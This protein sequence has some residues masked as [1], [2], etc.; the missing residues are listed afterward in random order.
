M[1]VEAAVDSNND[2]PNAGLSAATF[3]SLRADEEPTS[4]GLHPKDALASALPTDHVTHGS[5]RDTATQ[6]IS[7]S[8]DPSV[9]MLWALPWGRVCLVAPEVAR[10]LSVVKKGVVGES[11]ISNGQLLGQLD[12]T[13]KQ[14]LYA[15]RSREALAAGP[16]PADA[17]D[18]LSW[19]FSPVEGSLVGGIPPPVVSPPETCAFFPTTLSDLYQL[20]ETKNGPMHFIHADMGATLL[21]VAPKGFENRDLPADFVLVRMSRNSLPLKNESDGSALSMDE[22][23]ALGRAQLHRAFELT[24]DSSAKPKSL[25]HLAPMAFFE[26]DIEYSQPR[27]V[28]D[29]IPVRGVL[30]NVPFIL[31]R[32]PLKGEK[33][34]LEG[35]LK[36]LYEFKKN[37]ENNR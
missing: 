2:M 10:A 24:K 36:L 13:S 21:S 29:L 6:F 20:C 27:R 9:P 14:F 17:T 23:F 16:I 12:P 3:R 33:D 30:K 26:A 7:L 25:M 18:L 34:D 31:V 19:H 5:K 37:K 11:F 32:V 22:L 15:E 1:T 35:T 4:L 28:T 8:E